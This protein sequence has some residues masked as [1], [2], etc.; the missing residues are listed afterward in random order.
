MSVGLFARVGPLR[1]VDLGLISPADVDAA[2]RVGFDSTTGGSDLPTNSATVGTSP[3]DAGA[4]MA[5]ASATYFAWWVPFTLWMLVHG[6]FQSPERTGRDT[7]YL[8]L[9]L[10]DAVAGANCGVRTPPRGTK[11]GATPAEALDDAASVAATMKYMVFH[12]LACHLSFVSSALCMTYIYVHVFFALAGLVFSLFAAPP[13]RDLPRDGTASLLD[14]GLVPAARVFVSFAGGHRS[15]ADVLSE[16]S[17]R[18]MDCEAAEDA[19]PE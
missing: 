16:A 15:S 17:L 5:L 4:L 3:V 18:R 19:V 1:G 9:M 10:T 8:R 13:R 11:L 2:A 6:R 14:L 12:A 7:I